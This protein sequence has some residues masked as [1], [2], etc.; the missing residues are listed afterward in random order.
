[1]ILW[2]QIICFNNKIFCFS[3]ELFHFLQLCSY[4]LRDCISAVIW[5]LGLKCSRSIRRSY[6]W[7]ARKVSNLRKT[8]LY[9]T[10]NLLNHLHFSSYLAWLLTM[11][12][13]TTLWLDCYP[14]VCIK[15]KKLNCWLKLLLVLCN[16]ACG[17]RQSL[18]VVFS[19]G[20]KFCHGYLLLERF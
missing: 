3:E 1:M 8:Q 6:S 19:V 17:C 5:M 10:Q 11:L 14:K 4:S 16:D 13:R 7:G 12:P 2:Y 18:L 20:L 9:T 15:S